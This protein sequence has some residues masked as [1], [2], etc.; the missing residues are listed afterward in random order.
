MSR[1]ASA[2]HPIPNTNWAKP[3]TTVRVT[4]EFCAL[5]RSPISSYRSA[6]ITVWHNICSIDLRRGQ[7]VRW[8]PY[9]FITRWRLFYLLGIPIF[10]D[11][12]WLLIL[13]LII[14]TL[15]TFFQKELPGRHVLDYFIMALVSAVSFFACVVLH[16]LGHATVGRALGMP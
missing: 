15:T 9:M 5:A 16:E 4:R 7:F 8:R 14:G 1:P 6:H 3:F 13:I 10:V 11:L 2:S 12:S